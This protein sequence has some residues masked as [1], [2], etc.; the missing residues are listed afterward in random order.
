MVSPILELSNINK[1]FG[2]VQANK[3]VSLAINK[4]TIHG[5]IGENGAGKSTLMSIVY[6]FYQADSGTISI[7]GNIVNLKSP[8]DSIESGIGMVHQHFM[9]V[10]NFS[11][12]ENIILGFEGEIVFGKKLDEAKKNLL[13]LCETYKLNIDL[14]SIISDLSVGFRQRVQILKALYRGAEILILDEPTGVLTP[15]EVDEL[16]KILRSLQQEGKTIVL[17]THK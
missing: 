1:S 2:H 7:N 17:I 5:I 15:Q 13:N 12:L 9:L 14:N 11:V 10:E 16:I 4:G 8:R 6:G 3:E